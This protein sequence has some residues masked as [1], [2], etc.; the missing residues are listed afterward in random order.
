MTNTTAAKSSTALRSLDALRPNPDW[1]KLPL[2]DRKGW[3]RFCFDQIAENIR[4]SV[5]PTPEDSATYIG[6]EHMDTGSLRVQRWGSHADLK[7]QKLRMRKGDILFARRNAYLRRVAIAP[8][9]GLF[10]AHG[11][12]LRAKPGV[13]LPEFLPFLMTSDRFMSRA[14][15][16][17]VGS[18]SPTINWTTLKLEE[19]GL[20]PLPQQ[21]RIAEILWAVDANLVTTRESQTAAES[22]RASFLR[23]SLDSL[24]E[25]RVTFRSVQELIAA[26]V[27]ESPQDGNHGELH[28]TTKDYVDDGIP[29]VMANDIRD[30]R[31]C[32]DTCKRI[33]EAKAR[34][35]RIGFARPGDVLLTHKGSIG[36]TTIV[37]PEIGEFIMLTP[38]V[39]YY[40]IKDSTRLRRDFLS[41]VFTSEQFQKVLE[42]RAKQSTRDY[43]GI[44]AQ[45][46]LPIVIPDLP[47]QNRII[48][49]LNGVDIA[50]S[51]LKRRAL[52]LSAVL[53]TLTVNLC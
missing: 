49:K 47:E 15:M 48:E 9:D 43:I 20:P 33:S 13:V 8:H 40:R 31:L 32:L 22:F 2:F 16:I 11:M 44:L 46:E 6:L 51:A 19:F 45:R 53:G 23:D 36:R 35:L 37:P 4:E 21:K 27:I 28:P 14:E 25:K 26:N 10:S 42:I 39:T 18:L 24:S 17:S 50:I 3:R 38:Q 1:A 5:M 30:G 12:I 34:G 52:G 7:G 41:A 29:F